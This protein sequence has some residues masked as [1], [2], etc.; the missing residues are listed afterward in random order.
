LT[1]I[2]ESEKTTTMRHY[3]L[4]FQMPNRVEPAVS[5]A[6]YSNKSTISSNSLNG[7][8]V[9]IGIWILRIPLLIILFLFIM[10]IALLL[11]PWWIL[12]Q[13]FEKK[14]PNMMD[15]YY[16]IVTWPLTIS[17]NIRC[18]RQNDHFIEQLKY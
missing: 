18:F 15:G 3:L 1:F 11:T 9:T 12:M 6:R 13:P 4:I 14:C 16:R 5:K 2:Y 7:S 17:K 8:T 10:P